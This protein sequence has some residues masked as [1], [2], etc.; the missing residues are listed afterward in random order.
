M[1]VRSTGRNC[2]AT[3]DLDSSIFKL[4]IDQY[5]TIIFAGLKSDISCSATGTTWIKMKCLEN[6]IGLTR[7]MHFS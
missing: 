6:V 7:N 3:V 2:S 5:N 4:I 1:T